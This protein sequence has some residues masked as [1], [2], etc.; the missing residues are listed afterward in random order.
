MKRFGRISVLTLSIVGLS[1]VLSIATSHKV[2]AAVSALVTV[3]NANTNPV[4]VAS[5]E[6]QEAV[7]Y[8]LT[9]GFNAQTVTIPSGKR[10]VIDFVQIN[11]VVQSTD[12]PVQPSVILQSSLNG[13]NSANFYLQPGPSPVNIPGE[14]QLFLAQPV[15]IY[16]DSLSVSGAFA[17]YSPSFYSLGV[18]I[19]GHLVPLS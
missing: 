10:L 2:R 7:Q 1:L 18:R 11:G 16:A 9:V 13:G 15:K 3:S 8:D 4:P 12:G 6:A 19:S 17:G 14:N 5:M